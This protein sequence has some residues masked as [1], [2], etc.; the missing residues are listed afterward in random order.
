MKDPYRLGEHIEVLIEL[1][2]TYFAGDQEKVDGFMRDIFGEESGDCHKP[3]YRSIPYLVLPHIPYPETSIPYRGISVS[4][5]E[6]KAQKQ[7][8]KPARI[9]R[10]N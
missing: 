6:I 5:P 9:Y 8:P 2:G 3:K 1:E 4:R 7:G 10:K